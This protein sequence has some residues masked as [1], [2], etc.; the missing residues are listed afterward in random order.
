MGS[1]QRNNPFNKM[2]RANPSAGPDRNVMYDALGR[3]VEGGDMVMFAGYPALR[4]RV[5]GVRPVLAPQ[6]PP[7]MLAVTFTAIIEQGVQGGAANPELI[8]IADYSE[9]QDY[10]PEKAA[11][12][13]RTLEPVALGRAAGSAAP[14]GPAGD[15]GGESRPTEAG[16]Q[17]IV[18]GV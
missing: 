12:M 1:A 3:V 14:E 18:P 5:A 13:G 7:G 2:R 9:M 15:A 10:T 17:I 11:E 6:A 16:P 4:W 8:K